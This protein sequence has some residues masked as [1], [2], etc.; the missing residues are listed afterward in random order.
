MAIIILSSSNEK[1]KNVHSVEKESLKQNIRVILYF[2]QIQKKCCPMI[3]LSL[4]KNSCDYL[5]VSVWGIQ[6]ASD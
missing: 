2:K 4:Q 1:Y 3:V 5:A 6:Y